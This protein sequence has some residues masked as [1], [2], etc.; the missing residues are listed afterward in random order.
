VGN[1]Q[2]IDLI[3]YITSDELAKIGLK[4][5][6]TTVSEGIDYLWTEKS[7]PNWMKA[8][9]SKD[10]PLKPPLLLWTQ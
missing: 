2:L 3:S 1:K 8:Q 7:R 10:L 4:D 6:T 9:H 5:E